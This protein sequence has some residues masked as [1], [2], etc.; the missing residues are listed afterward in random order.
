VNT[1][2][3][4]LLD[5]GFQ[6]EEYSS[7][8][9]KVLV[10]EDGS[11][12]TKPTKISSI[13]DMLD[14]ES[15]TST[16][17]SLIQ[18]E[19]DMLS[20]DW[21]KVPSKDMRIPKGKTR[22]IC[23]E[24]YFAIMSGRFLAD[25]LDLDKKPRV[26]VW[27]GDVKRIQDPLSPSLFNFGKY[28]KTIPK[29]RIRFQDVVSPEVQMGF[30][31]T[32]THWGAKLGQLCKQ[33]NLISKGEHSWDG[34]KSTKP[35]TARAL[36]KA[37]NHFL[38]G[39]SDPRW[40][41]QFSDSIY[42]EQ[43]LRD[44]QT[45]SKNFL[46]ILKTV[47]G[48]T[49]QRMC[50]FPHEEWTY[51]KYD[52][53]V[54]KH[55]WELLS[56]GFLDGQLR[57]S[58]RGIISRYSELK[59]A[60][61]SIK[62]ACH[63]D[64]PDLATTHLFNKQARWLRFL[65]P[66]YKGVKEEKDRMRKIYL[67]GTLSQTR[68]AGKPPPIVTLQSKIKFL[69]TVQIPDTTNNTSLL[70]I[71]AAMQQTLRQLPDS[72]FTGLRTKASITINSNASF[73]KTQR[74][75]GTLAA[76]QEFC[77]G[78][79]TGDRAMIYDLNTGRPVQH[80]SKDATPGEYVFWRALE[81]VLWMTSEKR[82]SASL[83]TVNEPGKARSITKVRACVKI[84]LDVV[85]KICSVPLAKGFDSSSSGMKASHHAWNLFKDFEKE[86]FGD[87]L[88]N[89]KNRK[90]KSY[91]DYK[92]V[93]LIYERIFVTSTDFETATDFLSHKVAKELGVAWM[94]K[95]G[96]PKLLRNL[97]CEVAYG[98]RVIQFYGDVGIGTPVDET[99][100]LF[101]INTCRGVL[102]GDPLTKIVLHFVN[103][104]ARTIAENCR[105]TS[106][107]SSAFGPIDSISTKRLLEE[108]LNFS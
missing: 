81:E 61:K 92:T 79:E 40:T 29:N 64:M 52:I 39:K 9:T 17:S 66:L 25:T 102:M 105:D 99:E 91:T 34:P 95:C 55:L 26:I 65:L 59:K 67:I 86:E 106:L 77:S 89:V 32:H 33:E 24:D 35:T 94:S 101:S 13:V 75:G 49:T 19:N 4:I 108:I 71:R 53:L 62:Q 51:E 11:V 2:T 88:F 27:S 38:E 60:R 83:V 76:V 103:I 96:I 7:Q 58:A 41:Q 43:K 31:M 10:K 48:I 5:A 36:K 104:I 50:C 47:D 100:N 84:V 72:A 15:C 14:I 80:L 63:G 18:Q 70:L 97:V 37:I 54:L 73:E 28:G 93:R 85:N 78:R 20:E 30:L 98:P 68:G 42:M 74:D 90:Q 57:P 46:E 22:R 6:I 56:D 45:R 16:H 23:Y 82:R 87:I 12:W 107:F 8:E 69:K 21:N 44:R 1:S 3:D